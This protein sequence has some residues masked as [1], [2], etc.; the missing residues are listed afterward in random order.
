M[1]NRAHILLAAS[2]A[3]S[4]FLAGPI[5]DETGMGTVAWAQP[6]LPNTVSI[7]T[8][9]A[10]SHVVP[11]S[12][13][14]WGQVFLAPDTLIQSITVWR[15]SLPEVNPAPMKLYISEVDSTERPITVQLLLD[16]PSVVL[17]THPDTVTTER[18]DFVFDPP[19]ALP[20]TG[21]FF[22]AIKDEI[23]FA[24]FGLLSDT[25]NS[26]PHGKAWMAAPANLFCDDLGCC[27]WDFG[28]NIDL[29]FEIEFCLSPTTDVPI[30]KGDS[31]GKL[32]AFYR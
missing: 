19:F 27:T 4:L 29:I 13:R 32:K 15:R 5:Q 30:P 16:G 20:R 1:K 10:N 18:V 25:T 14:A 17:T 21:K 11:W 26:Y 8:S 7:D 9:M 22:F 2:I 24:A 28:G 6:C 23:C 31:W 12:G 3:L